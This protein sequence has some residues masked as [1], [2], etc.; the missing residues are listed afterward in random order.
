M[1]ALKALQESGETPP[2]TVMLATT[3]DKE[4]G[5]TRERVR[6]VQIAALVRLREISQREGV[7]ELPYV[8]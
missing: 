4:I 7:S 2:Q 8:E 5:L 3:I 1:A 6:Q